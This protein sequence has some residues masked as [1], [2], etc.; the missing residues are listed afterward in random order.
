MRAG[1]LFR[2]EESNDGSKT[3]LLSCLIVL[4]G[5]LESPRADTTFS[6]L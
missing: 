6:R 3:S 4:F 5:F 2:V 1:S